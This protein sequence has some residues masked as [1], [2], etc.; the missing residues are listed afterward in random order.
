M[1]RRCGTR[2]F[3]KSGPDSA[4]SDRYIGQSE[5]DLAKS[6][7]YFARSG[8][9]VAKSGWYF[10]KSGPSFAKSGRYFAKSGW[11]FAKSGPN[12]AKSARYFARSGQKAVESQ[13]LTSERKKN[14]S[15]DPKPPVPGPGSL[16]ARCAG[17]WSSGRILHS[18]RCPMASIDKNNKTTRRD[19]LR[20]LLN[21]INLHFQN[22]TSLT[23]GG[24]VHQISDITAKITADIAACDAADKGHAAW[25][26]LVDTERASH[27]VVDPLVTG[28]MQF[29]RLQFGDTDAVQATLAD[30]G[31]EP[32]KKAVVP[33][34]TKVAAAAKSKATRAARG[35]KGAKAK[36][37]IHG[38][39][40]TDPTVGTAPA[41]TSPTPAAAPGSTTPPATK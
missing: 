36:A 38:A 5:P 41:A 10:A 2:Y 37:A 6:G 9:D 15:P 19:R 20:L 12:F 1:G 7:R 17:A 23:I 13:V 40:A 16:K 3:A 31:M 18:K 21:G 39:P 24:V 22:I 26:Q 30:F 29:V 11:Y 8:R 34:A 28:V 32:T 25:L 14:A 27:A 4:K 35:T 33:P